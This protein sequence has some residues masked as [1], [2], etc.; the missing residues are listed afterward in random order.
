MSFRARAEIRKGHARAGR[1]RNDHQLQAARLVKSAAKGRHAFRDGQ[2]GRPPRVLRL[3]ESLLPSG[4]NVVC[5]RSVQLTGSVRV[6]VRP[7]AVY[8]G[9]AGC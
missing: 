2:L 5:K 7:P 1:P 6:Y 9:V 4:S 8:R 3:R